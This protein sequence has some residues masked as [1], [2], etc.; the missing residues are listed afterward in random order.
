MKKTHID[1]INQINSFEHKWLKPANEERVLYYSFD[2]TPSINII[3]YFEKFDHELSAEID[4]SFREHYSDISLTDASDSLKIVVKRIL[5]NLA[6]NIG[7]EFI[8]TEDPTKSN[9]HFLTFDKNSSGN[10]KISNIGLTLQLSENNMDHSIVTIERDYEYSKGL[11]AHEIGHALGLS[12]LEYDGYLSY[13]RSTVMSNINRG[14]VNK[15]SADYSA[16]DIT[17]LR[18][19]YGH[20]THHSEISPP[21]QVP[22]INHDKESTVAEEPT[23]E[24]I[25]KESA[26]IEDP[27]TLIEQSRPIDSPP[28]TLI[29]VIFDATPD[30]IT[31][32]HTTA[33]THA[34]MEY[35]YHRSH[36]NKVHILSLWE[37]LH[38]LN[39]D[40]DTF[41]L[42]TEEIN[43]IRLAQETRDSPQEKNWNHWMES[44]A[45]VEW[46]N[47]PTTNSV[48]GTNKSDYIA[49]SKK[50][51]TANG[52]DGND[53]IR[54]SIGNHDLKG[55]SGSD[56]YEFQPYLNQENSIN[57]IGNT[58]KDFD[59]IKLDGIYKNHLWFTQSGQDLVINHRTS[60]SE[61]TI[62]DYYKEGLNTVKQITVDDEILTEP[63]IR[64]LADAMAAYDS[65]DKGVSNINQFNTVSNQ[66]WVTLPQV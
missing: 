46:I 56:I 44:T 30:V 59:E 52:F 38:Q 8:E 18:L 16:N 41:T 27:I 65:S 32:L 6:K 43:I 17:A 5:D 47:S 3:N 63:N 54:D 50:N 21:T 66:C 4:D 29:P 49:V 53:Y 60:R 15:D 14:F 61:L 55:G 42:T 10:N 39:Y 33:I 62:T 24:D 57:S 23:N 58:Q 34:D 22:I 28:Q 48:N 36:G 9:L 7:L 31:P 45:S 20:D 25:N 26:V 35:F 2:K 19:A 13:D 11:V 40:L 64:K 1:I 12:H 51:K 37:K